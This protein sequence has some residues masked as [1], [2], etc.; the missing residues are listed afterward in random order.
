MAFLLKKSKRGQNTAATLYTDFTLSFC[1]NNKHL[2]FNR[3]A[4]T[5]G[6]IPPFC[7]DAFSSPL[8]QKITLCKYCTVTLKPSSIDIRD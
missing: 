1:N 2:S 6:L 4:F 8:L 3:V 5:R 7:K